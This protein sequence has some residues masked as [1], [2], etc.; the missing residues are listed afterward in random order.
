MMKNQEQPLELIYRKATDLPVVVACLTATT[1]I[2]THGN[3]LHDT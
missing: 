3:S 1:T 2:D